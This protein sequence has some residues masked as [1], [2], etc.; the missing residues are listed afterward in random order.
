MAYSSCSCNQTQR[1]GGCRKNAQ[2]AY[3]SFYP[4]RLGGTYPSAGCGSAYRPNIPCRPQCSSA[5]SNPC[6][7]YYCGSCGPVDSG[8]CGGGCSCFPPM[9]AYGFFTQLGSLSVGAGGM[10][11]FNGNSTAEGICK[12]GGELAL[13]VGGVYLVLLNVSLPENTTVTSELSV[14]LNGVRATGGTVTLNGSSTTPAS[15]TGAQTVITANAGSVLT[16]TSSGTIDLNTGDSSGA[17][18]T[19]TLVKIA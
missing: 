7:P 5:P 3:G 4:E 8:G 16:V 18:V 17:I 6:F 12:D 14:R 2:N 10:V 19:L 11:P 15:Q 9:D 1:I 13:N